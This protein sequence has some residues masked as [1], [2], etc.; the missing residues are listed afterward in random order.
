M[1]AEKR[2]SRSDPLERLRHLVEIGKL[3]D[4]EK[5]ISRGR[6]IFDPWSKKRSLLETAAQTV[7]GPSRRGRRRVQWQRP[8]RHGQRRSVRLI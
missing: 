8:V 5:H 6:R 2:A 4:V 7:C 3:Y 1:T